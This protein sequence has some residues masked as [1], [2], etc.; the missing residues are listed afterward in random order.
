MKQNMI[1]LSSLLMCAALA[2]SLGACSKP[3]EPET[4]A[5]SYTAGT[6]TGEA[7]GM[8][9]PIVVEVTFTDSEIKEVK[10]KEHNET[11]GIGYGMTT[12]P[13]E[14][15]QNDCLLYTSRCV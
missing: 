12:K 6:Y 1:K 14:V 8:K 2:L 4:E 11:F 3:A 7:A 15:L 10:V 5:G 13:I 9:G